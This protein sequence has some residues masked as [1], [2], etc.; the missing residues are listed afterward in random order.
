MM[1]TMLYFVDATFLL[2]NFVTVYSKGTL[3]VSAD[4]DCVIQW[5]ATEQVS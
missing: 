3:T 2:N 4:E 1:S 5:K